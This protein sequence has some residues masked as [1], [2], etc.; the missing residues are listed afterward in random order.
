MLRKAVGIIALLS[1]FPTAA[2]KVSE[3]STDVIYFEPPALPRI[4]YS[5]SGIGCPSGSAADTVTPGSNKNNNWNDWRFTFHRFGATDTG[6]NNGA[7][8]RNPNSNCQ[9]HISISTGPVGWQVAI[10]AL[11]VRSAASLTQGSSLV[12]TGTAAL[13]LAAGSDGTNIPR[14]TRNATFLN[15]K[16]D[17]MSGP[18]SVRFDFGENGPWSSCMNGEDV[19]GVF[20]VNFRVALARAS[21][22]GASA[23]FGAAARAD[24]STA[25]VTEMLEWVWRR[26][27]P[28]PKPTRTRATVLPPDEAATSVPDESVT[29]LPE[30]TVG[31]DVFSTA[32]L[33]AATSGVQSV[34]SAAVAWSTSVA[35]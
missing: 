25:G 28:Q 29:D 30:I 5:F 19:V 10:K 13:F 2:C 23:T 9:I 31:Q 32:V 20:N 17:E 15:D 11:T 24:N 14:Q 6:T 3:P 1:L 4:D 26:C 12:V 7:A 27:T 16:K 35:G 22:D 21:Q 34:S 33:A 18:V 8:S